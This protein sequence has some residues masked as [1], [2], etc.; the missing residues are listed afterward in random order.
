MDTNRSV[1]ALRRDASALKRDVDRRLASLRGETDRQLR[2]GERRVSSLERSRDTLGNL[3]WFSI[4]LVTTAAMIIILVI[5]VVASREQRQEP[6]EPQQ[7]SPSSIDAPLADSRGSL[8]P[9]I[10]VAGTPFR[11]HH[12]YRGNQTFRSREP[13]TS[14][15]PPVK[16]RQRLNISPVG[17]T[18]SLPQFDTCSVTW[19]PAPA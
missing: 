2:D 4:P 6:G 12:R 9:G 13:D 3:F 7:R 8:S 17:S 19:P 16:N 18:V 10:I 11:Q 14:N 1:E 5:A 15:P